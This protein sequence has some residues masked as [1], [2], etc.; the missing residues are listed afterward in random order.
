MNR[1][2]FVLGGLALSM[3]SAPARADTQPFVP[4]APPPPVAP[5]TVPVEN[6]DHDEVRLR[7]GVGYFGRFDVP[8]GRSNATTAGAQMVGIRVWFRRV[9]GLDFA[10]GFHARL[11]EEDDESA[12][13]LAIAARA[14]LPVA[15]VITRHFTLFV[16]PTVGW[17]QGGETHPGRRQLN[18]ITGVEWT[19]PETRH[20][21]LRATVGGRVGGELHLG[22]IATSRLSLI[23][24]IGVDVDYLR[25]TTSAPPTPT[26]R[27]P[28]PRATSSSS[29]AFAARTT[30]SED[31]WSAVLGNVAIVAYF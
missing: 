8:L 17:G 31:A 12:S 23:G 3:A 25:G 13:A 22:F 28:E 2:F 9:I 21:G 5:K 29:S 14:S 26:S 19:P 18:P 7:L 6:T 11:G 20:R 24:T 27:D 16:A 30:I 1:A 15:L 10:L 4:W